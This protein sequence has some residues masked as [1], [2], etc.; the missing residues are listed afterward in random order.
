MI[1]LR[2]PVLWRAVSIE[3]MEAQLMFGKKNQILLERNSLAFY[4][5]EKI[6]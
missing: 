3:G 2:Q 6:Y 4:T 1:K 5:T